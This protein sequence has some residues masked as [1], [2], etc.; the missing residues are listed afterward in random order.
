MNELKATAGPWFADR[1]GR[2]WRRHPDELYENGGGVAGDRPI[3][4]AHVGWYG[5]D[6]QGYPAGANAALIAAA[7]ELY[8]AL[9]EMATFIRDYK[10]AMKDELPYPVLDRAE[11]AL[12][13]AR[14]E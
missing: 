3:A 2:I 5:E 7:L 1:D 12:K 4:S 9:D 13:K 11:A 10:A 14:G 6:V 8:T